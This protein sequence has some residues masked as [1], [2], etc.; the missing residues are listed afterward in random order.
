MLLYTVVNQNH[1]AIIKNQFSLRIRTDTQL[2]RLNDLVQGLYEQNIQETTGDF[3]VLQSDKIYAYNFATA[4]DDG[5]QGI[6]DVIR[7]ADLLDTTT[8]H[9]F[10]QSLLNPS[11][12]DHL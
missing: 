10:L 6:T 11:K 7:G 5:L 12:F 2:I 4:I 1:R 8:N 3:I 9:L